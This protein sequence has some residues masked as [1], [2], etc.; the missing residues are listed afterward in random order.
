MSPKF[1]IG[2]GS[3]YAYVGSIVSLHTNQTDTEPENYIL[4]V[5]G[6]C[7]LHNQSNACWFPTQG[8][9]PSQ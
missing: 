6:T 2:F 4:L 1:Q 8:M 5:F 3:H 7:V 9:P